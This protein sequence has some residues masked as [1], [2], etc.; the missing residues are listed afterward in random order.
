M[1]SISWKTLEQTGTNEIS[2]S[3]LFDVSTIKLNHY[4]PFFT[5]V[6]WNHGG[7]EYHKDQKIP[8]EAS[9]EETL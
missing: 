8:G 4:L 1:R 3:H 7:S 9:K 6:E 5:D 2:L